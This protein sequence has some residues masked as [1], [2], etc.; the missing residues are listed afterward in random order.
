[1]QKRI[2]TLGIVAVAILASVPAH[3]NS[4][5]DWATKTYN[6]QL[7]P[8]K[9]AQPGAMWHLGADNAGGFFA[10]VVFPT[11][12]APLPAGAVA[13]ACVTAAPATFSCT[14]AAAHIGAYH[15]LDSFGVYNAANG[16]TDVDV[17]L[18]YG[19]PGKLT[20]RCHFNS[21]GGVVGILFAPPGSGFCFYSSFAIGSTWTL[22][23]AQSSPGVVGPVFHLSV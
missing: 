20:W 4:V 17:G 6:F 7:D 16:A 2:L 11:T 19:A 8:A 12:D 5:P 10:E 13:D 22:F 1:M 15:V 3:A 9:L 21:G 18:D 23:G 14:G